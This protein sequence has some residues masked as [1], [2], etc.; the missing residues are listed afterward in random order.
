MPYVNYARVALVTHCYEVCRKDKKRTIGLLNTIVKTNRDFLVQWAFFTRKPPELSWKNRLSRF[1]AEKWVNSIVEKYTDPYLTALARAI[2]LTPGL[3]PPENTW[4]Q[5]DFLEHFRTVANDLLNQHAPLTFHNLDLLRDHAV[6]GQLITEIEEKTPSS[7]QNYLSLYDAL[8]KT[9]SI[10]LPPIDQVGRFLG[11]DEMTKYEKLL[12]RESLGELNV[13]EG[14]ERGFTRQARGYDTWGT[15]KVKRV[16][17]LLSL[18]ASCLDDGDSKEMIGHKYEVYTSE[19]TRK[20]NLEQA[21]LLAEA[22]ALGVWRI[23]KGDSAQW[24]GVL[25]DEEWASYLH[26][27]QV[28]RNEYPSGFISKIPRRHFNQN[29]VKEMKEQNLANLLLIKPAPRT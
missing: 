19:Q 21:D 10:G 26:C 23:R 29:S 12:G 3:M 14:L 25:T 22:K 27:D 5:D 28:L 4:I 13:R 8:V 16:V 17:D 18:Y 11:I 15:D 24:K 20:R 9:L 1:S 7:I 6:A 2:I